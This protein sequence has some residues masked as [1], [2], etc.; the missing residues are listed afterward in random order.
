VTKATIKLYLGSVK[1]PGTVDVYQLISDWSE[2]TIA[3]TSPIL[4]NQLQAGIPIQSDQEGKFLVIEITA[5]VQQW[6]GTDGLGTGGAPNHG[7]ALVARDGASL[8]IDSKENSQT[9]HEPQLNIQLE[10]AAGSLTSVTADAPLSVTN[11]TT[12][13]HITLGVVPADKGGTGLSSSGAAGNFLRSEGSSW[14]SGPL[15]A[16]DIPPGSEHYIQNSSNPQSATNFNIGGTG[17]ADTLNAATQF[18]LGG[19]RV[20]SQPGT[21]N[22]FAGFSAGAANTG[23]NNSFFGNSAGLANLSG[24]F[25]SFFGSAAG[26]LNSIGSNNSFFGSNAGLANTSGFQNSFFGREAG[27]NNT[28]G[29]FNSFYGRSAG[30]FNTTGSGNTLFGQDAGVLN[31]T[32]GA[33]A[34]F[35]TAA[36]QANQTGNNNSFFGVF[37][38]DTNTTGSN[39]TVIGAGADV[40]ANNLNNATAIGSGAVVSTNNTIVLGRGVD[41]V[42]VPGALNVNGTLG[43]NVL[44]AAT[45]FNLG[46]SRV[47]SNAGTNNFFAGVDA[48]VNNT[49]GSNNNFFGTKAG[50]NNTSG[51]ANS[52]FGHQAGI[53]NTSGGFNSFFGH[54]AGAFSTTGSGNSFFGNVAGLS[55][56]TGI[57]NAF[58]GANAGQGN[59]TGNLNTF[60]GGNTGFDE[61]EATGDLNS[62]FGNNARVSSGVS[63]STAIGAS[64]KVEQSNSLVLGS[65]NG[66]NGAVANTNVG[67]GTPAPKA[68]LE[69]TGGN[70]LVGSPGQGI[71]LKSPNSATC[72]LL[73]IDNAGGL[74][75]VAVACP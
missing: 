40:A 11:P 74:T 5:A 9:S 75:L 29:S 70:I 67:I 32:G 38:G 36:G 68:K 61:P 73:S 23:Q 16:P 13:P 18:N 6:L 49:T 55:T 34:F 46:G 19:N 43:A 2:Q 60:V 69:V 51:G 7:V 59:T 21:N 64:A 62:S 33:N 42:Q 50:A 24:N 44:N 28:T 39:N 58:F 63:N 41:A 48:G 31:T 66:V 8:T 45:Q 17:S 1:T 52:F 54:N 20:L 22:L 72:R 71:I 14:T 30:L 57:S 27:A 47:L 56:T 12:A 26:R 3:S 4:G 35:G 25:N 65:I 37:A 53:S 15:L 10:R